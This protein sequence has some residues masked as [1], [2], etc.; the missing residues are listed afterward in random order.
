MSG[1]RPR[2]TPAWPRSLT[3]V[4]L[5]PALTRPRRAATVCRLGSADED[6]KRRTSADP[7]VSWTILYS[8]FNRPSCRHRCRRRQDRIASRARRWPVAAHVEPE[9]R[10]RVGHQRGVGGDAEDPA[11]HAEHELVEGLRVAAGEEQHDAGEEDE[12]A[13]KASGAPHPIVAEACPRRPVAA[14]KDRDDEVVRQGE[15]PPL[16]EHEPAGERLR[17]VDLEPR[18][19]VGGVLETEGRVLIGAKCAVA[20]EA[21]AP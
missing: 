10:V 1:S 20:V 21:D 14:G 13:D 11:V 8:V 4:T 17:I 6:S 19:V 18:R 16:H 2:S 5:C 12:Q 9:W 7:Y 3:D 15:Q